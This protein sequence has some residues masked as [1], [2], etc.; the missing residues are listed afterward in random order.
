[1]PLACGSGRSRLRRC[2]H[3]SLQPP[4]DMRLPVLAIALLA[5][6]PVASSAQSAADSAAI[7]A[8][9]M[10]YIEGWYAPDGPRMGRP[11]H[12]GPGRRIGITG[13]A[14]GRARVDNQGARTG[15]SGPRG[16][17]GKTAPAEK[18]QKDYTLL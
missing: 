16:G 1:M 2:R 6:A 10:D 7:H 8:T 13:P 11:L 4:V 17:G 5:L 14:G 15:V 18:Q 9:A 3:G 12:P